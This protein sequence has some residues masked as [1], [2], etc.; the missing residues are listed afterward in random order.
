[1]TGVGIGTFFKGCKE[2]ER[3]EGFQTEGKRVF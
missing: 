1:M 2:K 3:F